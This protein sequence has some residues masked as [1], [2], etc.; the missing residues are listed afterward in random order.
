[1]DSLAASVTI[2]AQWTARN[3]VT[4][5]G[6]N[7]NVSTPNK[8]IAL[9]TA[10]ANAAANGSNEVYSTIATITA[11]SSTT[12]DLT[13]L[14]N[15][16]GTTISFARIKAIIIQLLSAADTDES[17]TAL[18]T[19]AEYVTVGAAATNQFITQSGT[20][21]LG[22]TA[23]TFDIPNGGFLAFAVG[24]AAGVAVDGTHK[25]LKIANG[26]STLSAKVRITLIGGST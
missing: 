7:S 23:H 14:A 3:N 26:S 16:L 17:G 10:A 12:L 4:G 1:M 15:I 20:G 25:S 8:A 13:S 5:H 18:G 22:G 11:S 2:G 24:N 19:A 6:P 9:G 21:F